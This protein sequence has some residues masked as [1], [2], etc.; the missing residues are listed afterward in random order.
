LQG[1]NT[2]GQVRNVRFENVRVNGKQVLDAAAG[3]LQV[4]EFTQEIIF[5]R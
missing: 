5:K 4:G 3:N 1:L 2:A